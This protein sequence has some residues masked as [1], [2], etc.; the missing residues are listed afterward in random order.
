MTKCKKPEDIFN[1]ATMINNTSAGMFIDKCIATVGLKSFRQAS[2]DDPSLTR[3]QANRLL[4]C[5][6]TGKK[7]S[8]EVETGLRDQYMASYQKLIDD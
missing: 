5:V 2:V 6:S 3:V 7:I 8:E 1:R 4:Y